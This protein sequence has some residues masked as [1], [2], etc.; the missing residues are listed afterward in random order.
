[1]QEALSTLLRKPIAIV[2]AGRTDAG[3]HAKKNGCPFRLGGDSFDGENLIVKLNGFLPKDIAVKDIY[4][5]KPDIHA[6]FSAIS[7]TY[8]YYVTTQKILFFMS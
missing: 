6:R 1:M 7:R 3:V 8:K 4:Q 5:V 2:G